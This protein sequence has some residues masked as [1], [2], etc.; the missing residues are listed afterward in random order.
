LQRRYHAISLLVT[1]QLAFLSNGCKEEPPPVED[2]PCAAEPTLTVEG[3]HVTYTIPGCVELAL[4]AGVQGEGDLSLEFVAMDGAVRPVITAG[5]GGG[6]L[7]SASLA[8]EYTLVGEEP[9]VLW[10]Q[11]YQSWS[12]SGVVDTLAPEYDSNGLPIA[13]GDGDGTSITFETP[14]TSWWVGLLGRP[15]GASVLMGAEIAETTR[16]YTAFSA[17]RA[18]AVWGNRGEA[19][20]LAAGE[21][22]SLEP[23]WIEGS[24]D[25]YALHQTYAQRVAERTGAAAPPGT[26]I[27]GWATWY[28]FYEAVTEDDVR[29]NLGL[30]A[31]LA[32]RDDLVP[33][34]VFQIDDGWQVLWGDWTAG[35][36]FPSGMATLA[37]D[38]AAAGFTPG[39]WM[40][41]FYVHRSTQT[42]ADHPDWWVKDKAGE[43]IVFSNVGTGDY[44]IIDATHP[45]AGPWMA[46]QVADR[47]AEGWVYLKLDFLY[48]GAQEGQRAQ[49]VTGIEAYHI[50]MALL[51]E[52]AG[53]SWV[54]A[55]GAPLLPSV[56]YAQSFRTGSDIAFFASPDPMQPY[57][58]W[59]ARTTAA[60]SWFNG[61]WWWNDPDQIILREPFTDAQAR[62]A[63]VANAVSGGIWMLGDD[64]P[65][66]PE[67]RLAW[68]LSAEA[69]ATRGSL[70]EPAD[71]LDYVSGFDWGPLAES[72]QEDDQVPVYWQIGDD[73]AALL[74]LSNDPIEASCPGGTELLTGTSCDPDDVIVLQP[75]DGGIWR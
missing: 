24:R 45:D 56:G 19:I 41:P 73:H 72:V 61:V 4:N 69:A 8:G 21:T 16:F 75:G 46:Q 49:D 30:A 35:D 22:I 38:I 58:R 10:R 27:T 67:Q 43:D 34:D 32:Q 57:L 74:N 47:V 59:Q 55:C 48:A 42:Y 17:D 13:G 36:D 52:A 25:P 63:V 39:L 60:R 28:Q 2:D 11:G 14:S 65:A 53:D 20:P 7:H 62:G 23:L 3:T 40:A 68:A 1:A 66:L 37:E 50:G 5:A 31:E 51:R 9:A 33:M 64:L 71:P 70:T 29:A 44:V 54:L 18:F 6:T 12:W 26:P 15:D